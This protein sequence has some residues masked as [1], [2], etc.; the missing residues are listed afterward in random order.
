MFS[1]DLVIKIH[2][3]LHT[4][5]AAMVVNKCDELI[6]KYGIRIYVSTKDTKEP[7]AVSMLALLSLKIQENDSINI[8]TKED[9]KE[10]IKAIEELSSFITKDLS[11]TTPHMKAIDAILEETNIANEQIVKNIPIGI[12]VIDINSNITTINDYA[13]RIIEKNYKDVLGKNVKDIIPNSDLPNIIITKEKHLG[14]IQH[15]NN[16]ITMVNRSPIFSGDK[17]I[18][19]IGVFQDVSEIVGMKEV[20]ERFKKI[21]AS[22][23]DMIC[24][25]DENGYVSYVNPAY[26]ENY[27]LT[28]NSILGKHL[29]YLSPKGLRMQVFKS[30]EKIENIIYKKDG[31]NIISTVEPIFID[32]EFKGVI[33][34]SKKVEDIKDLMGKLEKS[35]T[36]LDYYKEELI[37]HAGLNRTFSD[38][39][40]ENKGLKKVLDFCRKAS[41]STSTVLVTGESG[42]GKELIA[43]AI[44]NNSERKD[45]PFVKVNCAAIPENLLESE[46]FGYEKGA[47]TGAIKN[48][49]GKFAIAD[50]GTI[51]LDEIGDMPLAMQA[52]L[53]RV[54]QEMEI[55]S[56]GGLS[57]QKIDVRVIAATNRNLS[58][59][60]EDK[61]FREDL[62]YRLNVIPIQI[63]PLK[64]RKEDIELLVEHF[65]LKLN[66]KLNKNI[67]GISEDSLLLLQEYHWP[68]N[69]REL[70]NLIERAMNLCDESI[71][72]PEDLPVYLQKNPQK[73]TNLINTPHGEILT[74]QEYEKEIIR[75]AMEKYK[76]FNKAGKALG[77]THRTI[78]LKCKK[79]GILVD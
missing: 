1:K 69:I 67:K 55:E 3:G 40:G 35:Q 2:N 30:K 23:H 16:H 41:Q 8:S 31:I 61:T 64:E 63:P 12:V 76:S 42:T 18:G 49:P 21:L 37:K 34:T 50:G 39:I 44:H 79:Y 14:K 75:L 5:V 45:K 51:F 33:S 38:I 58:E 62:Y 10:A 15:M 72:K 68:G 74:F 56:L 6:A 52:K 47:F 71:I 73:D 43:K 22:S 70:Q 66:K 54:L 46:L 59:M 29:K 13:L 36:E 20:N 28:S 57:P 27:N 60:I 7:I 25:I 19:A 17:I 48:K 78:S 11:G 77:L 53:L 24:F 9:S 4:R 26:E 65:I 32:G